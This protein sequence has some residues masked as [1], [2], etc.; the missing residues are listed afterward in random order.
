MPTCVDILCKYFLFKVDTWL[1][2]LHLETIVIFQPAHTSK[3]QER[4][5]YHA[6][7]SLTCS[8]YRQPCPEVSPGMLLCSFNLHCVHRIVYETKINPLYPSL[9]FHEKL[10]DVMGTQARWP[11][12]FRREL[13]SGHGGHWQNQRVLWPL[14]SNSDKYLST[15]I[16]VEEDTSPH[17]IAITVT[18]YVT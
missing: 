7:T 3:I 15:N 4:P 14:M 2:S 18:T 11:C 12:A 5:F 1:P 9:W 17:C 6:H 16:S 13:Y 10:L 8:C